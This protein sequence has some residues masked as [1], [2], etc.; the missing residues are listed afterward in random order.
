MTERIYVFGHRQPDTDSVMSAIAYSRLKNRIDDNEYVPVILGDVNP[1]TA[2]ILE[3]FSIEK[4]E[5]M[6]S[7]EEGQKVI[8]VDHNEPGQS[9]GTDKLNILEII[10]HH[11]LGGLTTPN[12]LFLRFEPV[13]CTATIIKKMYQENNI[14]ISKEVANMLISAAISDTLYTK[15]STTTEDDK[16]MIEELNSIAQLDL[17]R[18]AFE[19]FDAKGVIADE[20]AE[21]IFNNDCKEISI[22]G[23]KIVVGQVE[24]VNVEK[25]MA[26]KQDILE[27]MKKTNKDKASVASFLMVTD[28]FNELSHVLVVSDDEILLETM[29][30]VDNQVEM[31]NVMSR[32]K[33]FL[34]RM[35]DIIQ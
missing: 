1:E 26:K 35:F 24:T 17:D 28:I 25:V 29:E 33:D 2:F 7:L 22:N 31:K 18:F 21:K 11:K 15:S 8:L 10:D 14:E 4:P 13:G 3:N 12:P 6:T 27:V 34:P 9:I 30:V 32:K 23:K 19:I 5:I 20:S 16:K